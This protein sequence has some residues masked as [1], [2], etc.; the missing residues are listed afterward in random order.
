MET[1]LASIAAGGMVAAAALAAGASRVAGQKDRLNAPPG[2]NAAQ[3][4]FPI[5]YSYLIRPLHQDRNQ[6]GGRTELSLFLL[7]LE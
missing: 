7:L 5:G 3:S 6:A 4:P 2:D 1:V